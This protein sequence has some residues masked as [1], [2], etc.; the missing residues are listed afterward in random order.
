MPARNRP[1]DVSDYA[2]NVRRKT[3]AHLKQGCDLF[4]PSATLA[5]IVEEFGVG[6]HAGTK[7]GTLFAALS[8]ACAVAVASALNGLCYRQ[9]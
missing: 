1:F 4:V 5:S 8:Y 7:L 6:S 3:F 2:R 9:R